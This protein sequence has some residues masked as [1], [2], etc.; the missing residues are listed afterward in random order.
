MRGIAPARGKGGPPTTADTRGSGSTSSSGSSPRTAARCPCGPPPRM[1]PRSPCAC[2]GRRDRAAVGRAAPRRVGPLVFRA[3]IRWA[4]RGERE[5]RT[6]AG[7][8]PASS[9]LG[10][11][12]PSALVMTDPLRDKLQ[13]ALGSTFTVARELGGGGMSRVFLA[14]DASLGR[15]VVVKVLAPEL[16]EGI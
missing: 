15:R 1:A 6:G 3:L 9:Y 13:T 10:A 12:P 4:R 8:A 14:D 5:A 2:R 11:E 16:A 7:G